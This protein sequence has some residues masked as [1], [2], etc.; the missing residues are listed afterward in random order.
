MRCHS[1][2]MGQKLILQ[3]FESPRLLICLSLRVI[4][5]DI[6]RNKRGQKERYSTWTTD[7]PFLKVL[8][9]YTTFD[10]VTY[11]VLQLFI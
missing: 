3:K 10:T 2:G 8:Q 5:L 9:I 4:E 1:P 7:F 11:H 6:K